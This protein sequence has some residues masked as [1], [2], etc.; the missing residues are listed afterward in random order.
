MEPRG[1]IKENNSFPAFALQAKHYYCFYM[2]KLATEPG[3][4]DLVCTQG[5]LY[6][7]IHL[8]RLRTKPYAY[9]KN[10]LVHN[11]E[12][13]EQEFNHAKYHG[14]A[15][16]Y[17]D[18]EE[19]V[20]LPDGNTLRCFYQSSVVRLFSPDGTLLRSLPDTIEAFC[21]LYSIA[22]D[23]D[24]HLWTADPCY[25]QVAQY[26]V[27]TGRQ[28]F[29]LGGSWD[30]GE[31]DHPED[32]GIYEEHA[33]I[34]DMGHYRLVLLNTRTKRFSTYR[35]FEQPVW[36]YRRFQQHEL[37]RLDDGIYIL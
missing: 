35:T 2:R 8:T 14:G 25:H 13:T 9:F 33:F 27:A 22:L 24:G 10:D 15:G 16:P 26:E 7:R 3:A 20:Y 1:I 6:Y 30:P 19:V 18:G 29:S 32:I 12:I 37:V 31:F 21:G 11:H 34:S 4:F 23:A 5:W 17:E 28:L 36:Q